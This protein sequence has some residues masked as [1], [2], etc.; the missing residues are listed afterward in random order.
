MFGYTTLTTSATIA[1]NLPPGLISLNQHSPDL[2]TTHVLKQQTEDQTKHYVMTATFI[3]RHP[4]YLKNISRVKIN[5]IKGTD[6]NLS[7]L[8]SLFLELQLKESIL[9]R[10]TLATELLQLKEIV[11]PFYQCFALASTL[12][13]PASG[14]SSFV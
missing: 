5:L 13:F 10:V 6:A 8:I 7:K 2:A 12:L 9:C 11:R 3:N 1:S 4:E 14:V